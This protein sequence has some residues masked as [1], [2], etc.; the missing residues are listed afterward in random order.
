MRKN[1]EEKLAT[2]KVAAQTY[3]RP[4]SQFQLLTQKRFLPFFITQFFGA[5]NDNVFKNALIIMIAFQGSQ[6]IKADANLLINISAALFIIPFFLFS[7]TAG[8]WIDKYEKS[9]SIRAIK[10]LEIII[11]LVAAFAFV[12]G[13]IFVLIALLFLMGAQSTFFGPA[14]YSYIPQ[15]L[16]STE[17]VE[18][19][20]WVQMGTFVAIL[21]GTIL[22]GVLIAQENGRQYVACAI[23]VFA[24]T[25]YFS[26]RFIPLTPSL[27]KN[28]KI[29]WNIFSETY[30]NIKFLKSNRIVFL[31]VLGISWFWF[32][33]ATYL[34]QLPNYTKTTLGGNEQVVTLLLTLFTLGIGTG[35][36]LCNWLS[37]NKIE[38][39]L[40]PFGS[41]GL[42]LFGIDLYFS[43]PDVLPM[44][45]LGLKD[46]LSNGHYRLIIDIVLIGFFGGLYIVP[47]MALVQQRSE[48]EHMSRVIAGNNI[49]NSLLMVL[50]A[51]VAMIVLS[52]GFSIAQLFLFV[53]VLNALVAIYIYSLVPEFLMRFMVWLLIHSIYRVRARGLSNIPEQG[54][55]LLVCNH[56][57]YVDVLIIAGCIRR[58]VRFVM[59]YKIYNLPLLNFIFRTAR[60]IPIAGKYE[61]KNLLKKAFD[62]ID[63]SLAEGDVVCIFPEGKLT[64]NGEMNTFR[65]G[66]ERIIK[67]RAVPVIPMALQGLWGS[68]FSRQ[69][70]NI[71]YRILKGIKSRIGLVVGNEVAAQQVSAKNLQ[72]EVQGLY[73]NGN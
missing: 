8:Q 9:K 24:V 68:A 16:K 71:F 19:N 25:G 49:I 12:Q 34:V 69:K 53:A 17:L 33:G 73:K 7:A 22:G 1:Q 64:A 61:D 51:V 52:S 14:K 15:H 3:E 67:R 10:L 30:R 29:N 45:T 13:Y 11:M 70:S 31:S 36:L 32:L 35:S 54:A 63:D 5:F 46:F 6:F 44:V 26:S 4:T 48:P 50:S 58:P 65:D 20:A 2:T 27:N 55:A 47:L 18:G 43:Q 56:V 72:D 28:L 38:I 41:I 39:G 57:S 42:T 66:V 62:D 23:V 40:V 60:A 37:D 59:H 21:I